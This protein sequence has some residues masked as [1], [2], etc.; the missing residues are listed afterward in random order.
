M[1]SRYYTLLVRHVRAEQDLVLEERVAPTHA[2]TESMR[3]GS[4]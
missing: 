2:A 4:E 3:A 1:Y